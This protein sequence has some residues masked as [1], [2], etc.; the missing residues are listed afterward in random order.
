M[1]G[2]LPEDFGLTPGLIEEIRL[3]DERQA[4]L[5]VRLLVSGC[6]GL[7]LALSVLVYLHAGRNAHPLQRLVM[8]PLLGALGAGIGGLPVAILAGIASWLAHPRHP[9][10]AAL[11]KYEA[12][13]A[14]IRVCDVCLL[15][16]GDDTPKED[17]AYC[18]RC[19]AWICPSCRH[20]YDRRAIAAMKRLG[21]DDAGPKA[22]AGPEGGHTDTEVVAQRGPS[23]ST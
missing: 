7:W 6:A 5:F 13:T 19:G 23:E 22:E 12:A 10:A 11:Q 2:V 14:G 8:A 15:A 16:N 21:R 9:G 4:R 3:R 1:A 20:R 17:V 18:S